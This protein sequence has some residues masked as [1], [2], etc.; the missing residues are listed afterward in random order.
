MKHFFGGIVRAP[1]IFGGVHEQVLRRDG[2]FF[3]ARPAAGR[4][5]PPHGVQVRSHLGRCPV[6]CTVGQIVVLGCV[7][8]HPKCFPH[9]NPSF[10]RR[11]FGK[12]GTPREAHA[13]RGNMHKGTGKLALFP[14]SRVKTYLFFLPTHK[15]HLGS[16]HSD[17]AKAQQGGEKDGGL[18]GIGSVKKKGNG[19]RRTVRKRMQRECGCEQCEEMKTKKT[20]NNDS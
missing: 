2:C 14:L 7:V 16:R 20:T 18:H 10:P 15:P 17:S 11:M 8:A 12:L 19:G 1:R 3:G 9:P 13:T 6:F 4:S 5:L